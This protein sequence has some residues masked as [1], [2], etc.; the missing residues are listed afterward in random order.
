MPKQIPPHRKQAIEER[1][2]K[3]IKTRKRRCDYTDYQWEKHLKGLKKKK[4]QKWYKKIGKEYYR[5]K[6][7]SER[8]YV[9]K[10]AV[11]WICDLCGKEFLKKPRLKGKDHNWQFCSL[12]C[13]GKSYY[14][15]YFKKGREK[16]ALEVAKRRDEKSKFIYKIVVTDHYIQ[17]QFFGRY[18]TKEE[19]FEEFDRL[20][21]ENQNVL[22][23]RKHFY[24]NGKMKKSIDEILLLKLDEDAT[25]SQFPNEY[26]KLVENEV[27]SDEPWIIVNKHKWN[28]E[29]KFHHVGVSTAKIIKLPQK[30]RLGK[31]R[32]KSVQYI[33]DNI[34][35]KDINITI[36]IF[37]YDCYLIIK[38]GENIELIYSPHVNMIIELY[39]YLEKM[40]KIN[41]IKN[42]LFMGTI[43]NSPKLCEIYDEVIKNKIEPIYKNELKKIEDEE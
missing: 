11:W 25:P 20:I 4:N 7:G 26:G 29:E 38:K 8:T 31:Y 39:N 42:I 32:D 41:K 15:N 37:V 13:S 28:V 34:I 14:L 3:G 2:A 35:F 5:E 33:L 9:I 30:N 36:E 1:E 40:G 22:L 27:I 16:I 23:P 10:K 6:L 17:R 24:F 43:N 12:E 21:R 18:I 19:A